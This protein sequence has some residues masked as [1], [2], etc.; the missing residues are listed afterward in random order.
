MKISILTVTENRPEFMPWLLWNFE[1][2]NWPDKE[3]IIVDSGAGPVEVFAHK[4]PIAVIHAPGANVPEKRNIALQAATGDAI[5]WLDDDDWRHPDSLPILAAGLDGK[6]AVSGG[7]WAW[8][9]ELA[10]GRV[11]RFNNR[12]AVNFACLLAETAVAQE[13]RFDERL[14]RGSDVAWM[15]AILRHPYASTLAPLSMFLC[16]DRNLGNTAVNHR[17]NRDIDDAKSIIGREAWGRTG[18]ELT[19][20][21]GR[22]WK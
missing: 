5:T 20:L 12:R 18:M 22:L 13:V 19:A 10:T 7:R 6:T 11:R 16:H 15:D 4:H 17:F 1:R 14:T 21:R 2:Q 3:L 8:F 9:L